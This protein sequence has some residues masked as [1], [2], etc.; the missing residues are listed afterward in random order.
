LHGFGQFCPRKDWS[1]TTVGKLGRV[2]FSSI[3]GISIASVASSKHFGLRIW[4]SLA[5][6]LIRPDGILFGLWHHVGLAS[7]LTHHTASRLQIFPNKPGLSSPPVHG[8]CAWRE[9]LPH[10]HWDGSIPTTN[11][12]PRFAHLGLLLLTHPG[13]LLLSLH[14]TYPVRR[15]T[16]QLFSLFIFRYAFIFLDDA[17]REGD[18]LPCGRPFL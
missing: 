2:F 3:R 5:R 18:D 15:Q 4:Q 13:L 8:W 10:R 17:P 14:T 9:A 16:D 11:R 12:P 1:P 7:H 6:C